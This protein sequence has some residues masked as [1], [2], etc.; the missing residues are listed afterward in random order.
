ML[1][2]LQNPKKTGFEQKSSAMALMKI[3][4]IFENLL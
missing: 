3:M 1:Y 2:V 4:K